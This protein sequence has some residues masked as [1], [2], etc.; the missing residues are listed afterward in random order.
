MVCP[1]ELVFCGWALFNIAVWI[2]GREYAHKTQVTWF[3][4]ECATHYAM[5]YFQKW[6]CCSAVSL[7]TGY[8][9]NLNSSGFHLKAF[10][11]WISE[12]FPQRDDLAPQDVASHLATCL[13]HDKEP[14]H[15]A[16]CLALAEE[17]GHLATCLPHTKD[18]GYLA[19]CFLL[20]SSACGGWWGAPPTPHMLK[21]QVTTLPACPMRQE[22]SCHCYSHWH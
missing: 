15:L 4:V 2:W 21:S 22:L 10:K 7:S 6:L 8:Y 18:P 14:D 11:A 17:Q 16:T 13:P 20:S 9:R 3:K 5:I 12:D 1:K 19:F